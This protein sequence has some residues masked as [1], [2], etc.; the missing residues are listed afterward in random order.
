M[1]VSVN[2]CAGID[3]SGSDARP[4]VPSVRIFPIWIARKHLQGRKLSANTVSPAIRHLAMRCLALSLLLLLALSGYA[5]A[6]P[7]RSGRRPLNYF[8]SK[9]YVNDARQGKCT[10]LAVN[11]RGRDIG[12][13]YRSC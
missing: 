12:D 5:A 4:R 7:P 2:G 10:A 1:L 9:A 11:M 3:T 6:A 8:K 13:L